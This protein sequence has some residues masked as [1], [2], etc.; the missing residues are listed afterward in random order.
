MDET[1]HSAESG[2]DH[3]PSAGDRIGPYVIVRPLGR[4]GM[5]Q[6]WLAYDAR[7]QRDVAL[8]RLII[9]AR[10]D[11]SARARVL[12]EGRAAARVTH[13]NIAA[14][15]DV[16]EDAGQLFIVMEYVEGES[17]AARLARGPL[18]AG[19]VI[20]IARQLADGLAAAHAQRVIHR[21]L[22]PGNVQVTSGGT[23][24]ILDFGVARTAAAAAPTA[25]TIAVTAVPNLATDD[26]YAGTQAYMSPEQLLGKSVDHRSD[27][28]SLGV[29]L[30]ELAVGHRPFQSSDVLGLIFAISHDEAPRAH[31]LQPSIPRWF[32]DVIARCLARDA[33]DRYQSAAEL[34]QV[35]AAAADRSARQ[36]RRVA[37]SASAASIAAV[38]ALMFVVRPFGGHPVK[39]TVV[40]VLP[41]ETAS[42]DVTA[43]AFARTM[44]SLIVSNLGAVRGITVVSRAALNGKSTT[45]LAQLRRDL[46]AEYAVD[47]RVTAM[48]PQRQI[49]VRVRETPRGGE[50]WS[51][52]IAG[53]DLSAARQVL[54]GFDAAFRSV[55]VWPKGLGES[56]AMRLRRL[57]TTNAQALTQYLQARALLDRRDVGGNPRRAVDLLKAAVRADPA[58]GIAYAALGDA[59]CT[60][61]QRTKDPAIVQAANDAVAA[62]LRAAPDADQAYIA[63]GTLQNVT[64]RRDAAV[65]SFRRAIQLQPDDDDPRRLLGL[66][67]AGR[68]DVDGGVAAVKEAIAL[69]PRSWTDHNT[70]GFIYYNA[71]RYADAAEEFRRVTE[72][73]P[74]SARG[75]LMLGAALHQSGD[76]QQAIGNYEH[77]VR[78]S[79]NAASYSNLAFTYYQSGRIDDAVRAFQQAVDADQSNAVFRRNLGD[80]LA[81]ARRPVAAR[82]AYT[83]CVAL[84]NRQLTINA[85]NPGTIALIAL[86]E[87]K[88][89]RRSDAE[90]HAA[91]ALA[92]APSDR[93]VVYKNAAIAALVNDRARALTLLADALRQGY[94]PQLAR[95]DDD[96]ARL[97]PLPE[98]KR[99]VGVKP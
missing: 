11:S 68:G 30:F 64:G 52:H 6:V 3:A 36:Y 69:R 43:E 21:D 92:L 91:E 8:K 85:R 89:G 90:R 84:G 65:E 22:K 98:F 55:G 71:A 10:D 5:G 93:E 19:E 82:D 15:Y 60:E 50:R 78:L 56:D 63:L 81:K 4:G 29:L 7:L 42:G 28:Y 39:P 9:R 44:E 45:D 32:S 97:R 72:L 53:D 37:I 16:V 14:V 18:P 20:A 61:Y 49:A 41:V 27:I 88:L 35:L 51:A 96:F 34:K 83:S 73:E 57:P 76:V 94:Q 74:A 33:A 59:Y 99:L 47:A 2:V 62:A 40:A 38:A 23:I 66:I 46:H 31:A 87:A 70:L 75:Y 17:L 1:P 67:L 77:A 58:F 13:P 80:A 26:T 79:P 12:R 54:A 86:C 48:D 95:E 25:E 24:K